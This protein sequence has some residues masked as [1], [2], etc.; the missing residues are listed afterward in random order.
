VRSG[1]LI[2][3]GRLPN[4]GVLSINGNRASTGSLTGEIP[5]RP[6]RV[7]VYPAELTKDGLKIYSSNPKHEP[8]HSEPPAARNGWNKTSY[9]RDTRLT[10]AVKVVEAPRAENN[11]NRLVLRD[12]GAKSSVLV[13]E[14][15]TL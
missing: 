8:G 10:G 7:T 3:T 12:E 2:W 9:V 6:V 14:W 15:D 1:T 13:I 11:W 5:A 4:T